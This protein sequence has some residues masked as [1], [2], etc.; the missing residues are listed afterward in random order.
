VLPDRSVLIGQKLVENAKIEK[1]SNE[2]FWVIFKQCGVGELQSFAIVH[3]CKVVFITSWSC[4][5]KC[6]QVRRTTFL[7]RTT[8]SRVGTIL[9]RGASGVLGGGIRGFRIGGFFR[10]GISFLGD[11][12][13][14]VQLVTTNESFDF[15]DPILVLLVLV[16]GSRRA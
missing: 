3:A 16:L 15:F 11:L 9:G 4:F 12:K 5:V 10:S 6:H 13:S 14:R 1:K 7:F 8:G 2:T